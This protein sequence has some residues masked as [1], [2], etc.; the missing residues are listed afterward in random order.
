MTMSAA[1]TEYDIWKPVLN[2]CSGSSSRVTKADAVSAARA[3]PGSRNTRDASRNAIIRKAR[4]AGELAPVICTYSHN[5]LRVTTTAGRRGRRRRR[6]R[7]CSANEITPTC[8]P[9]TEK[10]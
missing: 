8:S 3:L 6:S 1:T 10:R 9:L 4:I 2:S 7:P 5:T